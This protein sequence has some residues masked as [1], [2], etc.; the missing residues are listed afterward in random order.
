[1]KIDHRKRRRQFGH[2]SPAR[3]IPRQSAMVSSLTPANRPDI[4]LARGRV[5]NGA[6]VHGS[7][8][9]AAPNSSGDMA[10]WEHL[11]ELRRRVAICA[12]AFILAIGLTYIGYNRILRLLLHPMCMTDPKAACAL[13]VT[14]PIDAF[15]VRL[16]IAGYSALA[17]T[18]PVILWHLWKFVTPGLKANERRFALP[19]VA[20]AVLLFCLGGFVAM[21][22]FP[23]ALTFLQAAGGSSIREIYS[24]NRYLSLI[25]LL[26]TIFGMAFEMPVVLVGLELG[27]VLRSQQ[28]AHWR[29]I[30]FVAVVAIAAVITPSSDPFS[31][32]ALAAPL[33][34]FYEGSIQIGRL[35][36]K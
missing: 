22:T 24:P 29:R 25:L 1:M 23:H 28:L 9:H 27:G 20:A 32:L 11:A 34:F 31:M 15:T 3:M 6:R 5:T 14:S 7:L 33:A 36:G 18:S 13:Y 17:I 21:M 26:I 30:A 2:S 35:F 4:V 19:F 8:L 12:G 10:L 16:N